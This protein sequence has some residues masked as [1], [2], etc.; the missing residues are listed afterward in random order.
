MLEGY[1]LLAG[2]PSCCHYMFS[3][4]TLAFSANSCAAK[5][6]F[7]KTKLFK[8]IG[9]RH[10]Q[11]HGCASTKTKALQPFPFIFREVL[12]L[13][14]HSHL[15]FGSKSYDAPIGGGLQL[16]TLFRGPARGPVREK[17][18]IWTL[19]LSAVLKGLF[20]DRYS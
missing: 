2:S 11:H 17:F 1:C 12:S 20:D 6:L 8:P 5:L 13:E 16:S 4:N 18:L 7:S 14:L 15:R 19:I 10:G 9:H 3:Y